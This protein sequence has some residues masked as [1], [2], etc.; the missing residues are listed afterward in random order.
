MTSSL[1]PLDYA[2]FNCMKNGIWSVKLGGH[3]ALS[4]SEKHE[5]TWKPLTL[6]LYQF[7]SGC[8]G[9]TL[10]GFQVPIKANLLLPLQ[11]E[12]RKCNKGFTQGPREITNCL[13]SW[14]KQ[15][16]FGEVN[17]FITN[18]NSNTMMR[19]KINL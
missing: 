14:A 8:G 6:S 17:E 13:L 15:T 11:L 5:V 2:Y 18:Q 7:F 3:V 9:L 4:Y 10:A 19:S 12:E 16:Q 1:V